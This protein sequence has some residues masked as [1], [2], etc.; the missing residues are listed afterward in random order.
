MTSDT[1]KKKG[2]SYTVKQEQLEDYKNWSMIRR[3][4]WLLLG[5]KMRK[6]LPQETIKIQEAFRKA[7]I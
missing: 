1:T 2:F 6:S 5:N 4:R 3:M 7:E